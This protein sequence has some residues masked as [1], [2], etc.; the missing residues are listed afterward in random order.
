MIVQCYSVILS[1]DA[2]KDLRKI[3]KQD[4][5]KIFLKIRELAQWLPSLDV[6]QLKAKS[7]LYRLRVGNYRVVYRIEHE[8]VIIYV[9]AVG[10][11]KEVYKKLSNR[12]F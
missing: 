6:K 2:Q 12:L 10:H 11:R 8:K 3:D 7:K 1:D 4:V 5:S 9:I